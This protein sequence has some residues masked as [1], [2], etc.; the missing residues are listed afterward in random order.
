MKNKNSVII[1]LAILC[2]FGLAG[3]MGALAA[4]TPSLGQA[5]TFGVLGSS[6]INTTPGTI[7]NGDLGYT[8]GSAVAPVVSGLTHTA[9][10]VYNQAGIDQNAA[11][12]NLN[13]QPCTFTFAPGAI[14]LAIDTTHGPVGIY[15]PGVYC[16]LGAASVG[17]AGITL[18][19]SGTYIFRINGALTAVANSA[20]TL[21]NGAG[22]CDVFWTPL[23]ATTLGAN[24]T[25]VGTNIDAS[26]ITMGSNVNRIGRLLAFGGTVTTNADTISVPTC[27]PALPAPVI[28]PAPVVT[29][30]ITLP[31]PTPALTMPA[32]A[33]I[34]SPTFP[35]T[36]IEPQN[37]NSAIFQ[38]VIIFAGI[39]A[40]LFMLGLGLDR[41]QSS[42]KSSIK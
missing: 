27:A 33:P 22:A 19:G 30:V 36:G 35:N 15:T 24:S 5:A 31:T 40:A 2:A 4:T 14:D 10:S 34:T 6:F 21:A 42:I 38:T 9:D 12:S 25:F 39:F 7:I 41:K 32:A 37:S 17:T 16:V 20:V 11:L 28:T 3:P 13:S 8:T 23:A 1:A 29:P 18:S 26:G